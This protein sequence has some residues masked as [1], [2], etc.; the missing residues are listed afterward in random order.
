MSEPKQPSWAKPTSSSTTISTLGAR[1][2]AGVRWPPRLRLPVVAP[3]RPLELPRFHDRSM[4]AAVAARRRSGTWERPAERVEPFRSVTTEGSG[5]NG[6][7][8]G[9]PR[10]FVRGK[11]AVVTGGATGMGR[12]LVVQLAAA[13]SRRHVRRER[14]GGGRDRR[15]GG[16]GGAAERG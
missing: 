10:G 14:A 13:E 8:E 15:A 11:L 5:C 9:G 7:G 6:A 4:P 1:R 2:R 3:D 12:E 16:G